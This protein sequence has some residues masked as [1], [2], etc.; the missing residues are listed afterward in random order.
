MKTLTFDSTEDR[1]KFFLLI[2]SGKIPDPYGSVPNC[3]K[4]C[5]VDWA[6]KIAVSIAIGGKEVREIGYV[7]GWPSC[8][9]I[10][11]NTSGVIHFPCFYLEQE[12]GKPPPQAWFTLHEL[13]VFPGVIRIE[14]LEDYNRR[15]VSQKHVAKVVNIREA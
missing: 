4:V 1:I 8:A 6:D 5:K 2:Q 9:S 11:A 7:I 15:M 12:E 14:L 13:R 3:D 10:D